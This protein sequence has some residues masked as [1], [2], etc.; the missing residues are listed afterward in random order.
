METT[1]RHCGYLATLAEIVT[2]V[3]MFVFI[4]VELSP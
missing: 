1:N 4:G 3:P 2:V